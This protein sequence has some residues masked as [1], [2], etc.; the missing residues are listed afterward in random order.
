MSLGQ[1]Q[2]VLVCKASEDNNN[3]NNICPPGQSLSTIQ[4]YILDSSSQQQF[5]TSVLTD[6]T[7]PGTFFALGITV[8]LTS[9]LF[10]KG[11]GAIIK[12]IK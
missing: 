5:E 1:V 8:I 12:V 4:A 10:A 9:W 11:F 7:I 6:Y 2:T 3:L